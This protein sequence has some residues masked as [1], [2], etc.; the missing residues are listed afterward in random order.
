MEPNVRC[1]FPA[2]GKLLRLLLRSSASSCKAEQSF[3]ALCRLKTWLRS[4]MTQVHLNHV[5]VGHVHQDIL[6]ELSCQKIAKEFVMSNDA[7]CQVSGRIE[8]EETI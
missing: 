4:T 6:S 2:V 3:S 5:V 1:M 7:R 8:T